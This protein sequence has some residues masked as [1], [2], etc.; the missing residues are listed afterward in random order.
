MIKH[1]IH[2]QKKT[3]KK[4]LPTEL[5]HH[6]ICALL[7]VHRTTLEVIEVSDSDF[8]MCQASH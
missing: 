7:N 4:T 2:L 8:I 3:K 5:Q 1:F 6:I